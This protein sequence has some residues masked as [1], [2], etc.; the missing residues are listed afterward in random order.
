M[1]RP[2]IITCPITGGDDNTAKFPNVPVT[3]AQIAQSA[4]EAAR[5]GAA[6]AHIHVRDPQ[7]G[8]QSLRL[9]YYAEVVDRVRSSDVDVVIN[10]TT[11]IGARVVPSMDQANTL[12]AGSNMQP[13]IERVQHVAELR[14]EICSLDM[15][16]LNFGT[17]ALVNIPR[18]VEVIAEVIRESGVK[19]ELE[20]FDTGHIALAR[21]MIEKG[22]I[23]PHPLWQIV[24]GVPWGAPASP[25]TLLHMRDSL[26]HGA[27][28]AAFGI[29][30][31]AYPM[32]AQAFLAGGHVRIGIE[33]TVYI[34]RGKL[35]PSNAALVEK[36]VH[37]LDSLGGE[38]ATANQAREILGLTEHAA[39]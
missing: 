16:S 3:P 28:W 13:P 27:C 38:P 39:A 31:H 4:I 9:E 29:S 5:A 8:Q 34:D 14:P 33:D 2:V 7:T 6:I 24:L 32:L 22:Q 20:V 25:S 1:S 17:G 21:D 36:A 11:G 18:H 15:G 35:A 12:A 23:T 26:P 37:L 10:L 19:P 30:R